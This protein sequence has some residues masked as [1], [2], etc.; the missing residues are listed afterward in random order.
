MSVSLAKATDS[1]VSNVSGSVVLMDRNAISELIDQDLRNNN[2]DMLF[3]VIGSNL[4]PVLYATDAEYLNS[5]LRNNRGEAF[6]YMLSGSGLPY[7]LWLEN[8]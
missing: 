4:A 7:R 3:S 6:Q 1:N 8:R 5:D 2:L